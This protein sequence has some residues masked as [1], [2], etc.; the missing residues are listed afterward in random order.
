MYFDL[1]VSILMSNGSINA[2]VIGMLWDVFSQ[3]VPNTTNEQSRGALV[4]DFI[5]IFF[6]IIIYFWYYLFLRESV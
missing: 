2:N 6:F 1:Q 5:S 3:A 4:G